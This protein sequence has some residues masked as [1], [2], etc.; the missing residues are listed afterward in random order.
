MTDR[1][2][3]EAFPVGA[4]IKEE[5]EARGWSQAD[6]ASII[7]RSPKAVHSLVSGKVPLVPETATLLAEAFGTS[8]Q[9]WMNIETAFRGWQVSRDERQAVARMGKL[10]AVAPVRE[11]QRRGWIPKTRDVDALERHVRAFCAIEDL[12]QWAAAIPHAARMS[13]EY[14]EPNPP[15]LAWLARARNLARAVGVSGRFSASS[16]A[17]CLARLKTLTTDPEEARHVPRILADHGI[18]FV[19][20]EHLP[21][22]KVDGAC[23][24]LDDESPVVVISLRYERMDWFWFTLGHELGHVSAGDGKT[25]PNVDAELVGEHADAHGTKQ[26]HEQA[27]DRFAANF[28]VPTG[29][30]DDF[31]ARVRP[32]YSKERIRLFSKRIGVHPGLVV[33]QLQFRGE[34]PFYHSRE[35]LRDRVREIVT[36]NALTDG[37]GSLPL[38]V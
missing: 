37:W 2:P 23:L 6:L 16:L 35:M 1:I 26:P 38:S 3:A 20:V 30:L 11:M 36:A 32:L 5:M 22:T 18:R 8:P 9:F 14:K 10:F 31:I 19:V 24:W 25:V 33:G 34:I 4:F 21:Q 12:D 29:E 28:L 17:D 27:A 13:R 15:L 7:G